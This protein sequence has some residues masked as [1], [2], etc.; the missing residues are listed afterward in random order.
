MHGRS[1]TRGAYTDEFDRQLDAPV[2]LW[3]V[4]D[5]V[6]HPRC[7]MLRHDVAVLAN[8]VEDLLVP[9]GE[10]GTS[11]T[12]V[13]EPAA[14]RVRRDRQI[15]FGVVQRSADRDRMIRPGLPGTMD[16]QCRGQLG[17]GDRRA[18]E[19]VPPGRAAGG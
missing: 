16:P 12:A 14:E 7:R 9:A 11:R 5:R 17:G 1:R 18:V 3:P 4:G 19:D 15:A 6:V 8:V 13:A 10:L 2:T